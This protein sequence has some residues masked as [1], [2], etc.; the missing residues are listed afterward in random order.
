M[1]AKTSMRACVG[2]FSAIAEKKNDRKKFYEPFEKYFKPDI[3]ADSTNRTKV[4][5]LMR[6]HTSQSGDEKIRVKK[7]VDLKR[8]RQKDV[9]YVTEMSLMVPNH[10]DSLE[11]FKRMLPRAGS[12]LTRLEVSATALRERALTMVRGAR[13]GTN[14]QVLEL[15]AGLARLRRHGLY[16]C[17][18]RERR[19][20]SPQPAL[21]A[22]RAACGIARRHRSGVPAHQGP[23]PAHFEATGLGAVP[24]PVPRK[25]AS[26]GAVHPTGVR[27]CLPGLAGYPRGRACAATPRP[28]GTPA[29]LSSVEGGLWGARPRGSLPVLAR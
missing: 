23:T 16:R 22:V 27:P 11:L 5:E 2:M 24:S 12:S 10:D 28:V 4:E 21:L 8:E 20:L 15:S 7:Y 17:Q 29:V 3:H 9:R 6:F 14:G 1:N 18:R 26:L 25:Q 13:W 19:G